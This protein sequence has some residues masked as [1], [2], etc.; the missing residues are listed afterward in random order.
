MKPIYIILIICLIVIVILLF[1]RWLVMR[2]YKKHIFS[3]SPSYTSRV[4]SNSLILKDDNSPQSFLWSHEYSNNFDNDPTK[5]KVRFSLSRDLM[6]PG[7][8]TF[9]LSVITHTII[10]DRI[11]GEIT[12]RDFTLRYECINVPCDWDGTSI[13][14]DPKFGLSCTPTPGAYINMKLVSINYVPSTINGLRNDSFNITFEYDRLFVRDGEKS[15]KILTYVCMANLSSPIMGPIS[16]SLNTFLKTAISNTLIKLPTLKNSQIGDN[17]YWQATSNKSNLTGACIGG[18]AIDNRLVLRDIY[19]MSF[20]N[21]TVQDIQL[22]YSPETI[23][24]GTVDQFGNKITKD[25]YTCSAKLHYDG[26]MHINTSGFAIEPL[27]HFGFNAGPIEDMNPFKE[28]DEW[29][30]KD[31]WCD[32]TSVIALFDDDPL[33]TIDIQFKVNLDNYP[34]V[35]IDHFSSVKFVKKIVALKIIF[36]NCDGNL[37]DNANLYN[38]INNFFKLNNLVKDKVNELITDGAIDKVLIDLL[39]QNKTSI[40]DL[41]KTNTPSIGV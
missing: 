14:F 41:I 3:S 7:E 30:S 4:K 35:V 11:T 25:L 9:S 16:D 34:L 6:S 23:D 5:E 27:C 13:N 31:T 18:H 15:K 17:T 2:I 8:I 21:F 32:E 22:F 37:E 38:N 1:L 24:T 40:N 39:T 19:Q 33:P 10:T 29:K 26:P 28:H 36:S 12:I 20:G